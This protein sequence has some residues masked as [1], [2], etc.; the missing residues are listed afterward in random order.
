MKQRLFVYGTLK[1]GLSNSHYLA[2]QTFVTEAQTQPVYRMADCGGYPGMYPSDEG[3]S[4][5]GE[6]WE[7]DA[8]ARKQLDILEDVGVGLY[9]LVP[10]ELLPPF[11]DADVW[12]Y[13]YR[14]SIKGKPDA[15][16]EWTE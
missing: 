3:L 14:W 11:N 2:G 10:V 13:L 5:H 8:E 7:V 12:T 16:A 1:R 6:I 15:G 4:I 9:E